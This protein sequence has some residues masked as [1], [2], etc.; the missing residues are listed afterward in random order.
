MGGFDEHATVE[1]LK[2]VFAV[3]AFAPFDYL[4]VE[5]SLARQVRV[6]VDTVRRWVAALCDLH[7]GFLVRPWF[8][9]VARSLR[10]E[11]KWYLRGWASIGDMER[12]AL[13][14]REHSLSQHKLQ[15]PSIIR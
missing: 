2:T 4:H 10:K 3:H 6:A 9:N 12:R 5:D 8:R 11:P 13:V 1:D 14:L 15:F 7:L